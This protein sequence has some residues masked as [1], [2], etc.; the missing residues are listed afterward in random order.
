MKTIIPVIAALLSLSLCACAEPDSPG[1]RAGQ[2]NVLV[3]L[4]DDAG[5][6]DFGFQ[7]STEFDTPRIDSI[8]EQGARY[9]NA[10]VTTPFC[11]P[12]RAGLLTGRYTQRFGYEFNLTHE[13]TPGVD[14]NYMG[15]AVEEKTVADL[16]K[17]AG[18]TTVAVGKWHVGD[19]PQYHPNRRGF[20]HFY[21]FLGGGSTYHPDNPK[22][23]VKM[24]RDGEPVKPQSYLTDDFARE[25]VERSIAKDVERA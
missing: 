8:A 2:P 14:G 11:S 21:G 17:G 15:L 4:A 23:S 6:Q 13:P 12:S 7:G 25:A 10:Y 3:I 18:Y 19:L 9:T 20:D 1:D 22:R 5:Y 24:L 16:M